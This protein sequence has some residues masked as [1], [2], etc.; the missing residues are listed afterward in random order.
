MLCT[1]VYSE[2]ER[3]ENMM[4]II[5]VWQIILDNSVNTVTGCGLYDRQ[6]HHLRIGT[7]TH[8][9]SY[10]GIGATFP[11]GISVAV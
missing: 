11:D 3:D 5:M 7:E 4:M 2:H 1:T 10:R 9:V 8:P 6:G